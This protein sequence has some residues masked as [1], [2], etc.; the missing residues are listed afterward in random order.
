MSPSKLCNN[1]VLYAQV[2]ETGI[3]I[4]I[5]VMD[6]GNGYQEQYI[7]RIHDLTEIK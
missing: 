1:Y 3:W 6:T 4:Y 5:M 2:L 7:P